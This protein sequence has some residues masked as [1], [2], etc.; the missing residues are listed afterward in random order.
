MNNGAVVN[1]S[2]YQTLTLSGNAGDDTFNVSPTTLTGVTT[3]SVQ[4]RRSHGQRY[5]DRQRRGSAP[6]TMLAG[7][8]PSGVGAWSVFTGSRL[9][10]P[11]TGFSGVGEPRLSRSPVRR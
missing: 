8:A 3:F 11:T 6:P 5:A 7:L 9:S 1:F 2:T 4:R 10:P